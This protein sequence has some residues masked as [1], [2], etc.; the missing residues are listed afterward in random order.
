MDRWQV[1]S[2]PGADFLLK[3]ITPSCWTN[4]KTTC[5]GFSF[6]SHLQSAECEPQ[7]FWSIGKDCNDWGIALSEGRNLSYHHQL[8]DCRRHYSASSIGTLLS[9]GWIFR[10]VCGDHRFNTCRWI[11]ATGMIFDTGW[12]QRAVTEQNKSEYVA[13][14]LRTDTMF[15]RAEKVLQLAQRKIDIFK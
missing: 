10:Q 14:F 1:S 6:G 2:I 4:E 9:A 3:I 15:R 8:S 11:Y 5:S 7:I 13:A 12:I